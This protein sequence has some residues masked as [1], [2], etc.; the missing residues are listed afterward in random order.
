MRWE[1]K[2]AKF[3]EAK[4]GDPFAVS[5]YRLMVVDNEEERSALDVFEQAFKDWQ[6]YLGAWGFVEGTFVQGNPI[7]TIGVGGGQS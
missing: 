1:T 3:G 7:G 5:I 6:R 2:A 4:F